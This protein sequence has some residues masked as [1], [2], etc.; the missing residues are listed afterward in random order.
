M[1][2]SQIAA[3]LKHYY[4]EYG[5]W[6]DFTADG[7][8]LD[9]ARQIRLLAVLIAKDEV[10]NPR[11]IVFFEPKIATRFG[12][13]GAYRGGLHPVTGAF[14]DPWGQPYRIMLDHDYDE[15]VSN[16]Y[17]QDD[18]IRLKVIAWSEGK[19]GKPGA[20]GNPRTQRGSDDI[21][22]WN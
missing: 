11:K 22:S 5:K 12:A 15:V 9:E 14:L 1:G 17:P 10:N 2:A 7:L 20:P 21:V 4:L 3:A 18:E 13:K 19:D 16:P 6:P 8:F